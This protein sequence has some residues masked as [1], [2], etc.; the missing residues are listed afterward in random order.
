LLQGDASRDTISLAHELAT[1]SPPKLSA[2]LQVLLQ[3]PE[4][5]LA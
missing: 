3:S 5:Q 2:A 1:G 4:Y